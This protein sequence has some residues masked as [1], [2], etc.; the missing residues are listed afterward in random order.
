MFVY[1]LV[2]VNC[3]EEVLSKKI[4][5]FGCWYSSTINLC[6][7]EK[8]SLIAIEGSIVF[9]DVNVQTAFKFCIVQIFSERIPIIRV[10]L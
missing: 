4:I 2:L 8:S 6:E 7:I 10:Y 5:V 3:K 9:I 1:A